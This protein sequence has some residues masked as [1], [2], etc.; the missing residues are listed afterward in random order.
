MKRQS[1]WR[2]GVVVLLLLGLLSAIRIEPEPPEDTTPDEMPGSA[3][4]LT[5]PRMPSGFIWIDQ[6]RLKR[7]P[8]E[9]SAWRNIRRAALAPIRAPNWGDQADSTNVTV[10]AKALVHARTGDPMMRETVIHACRLGI[11]SADRG[12]ALSLG[13]QLMAYVLAADLVG[14]PESLDERF[15]AELRR[16][17]AHVFPSGKT[18]QST[19]RTRPNNWGTF[20]GATRLAIAAYLGDEA[21]FSDV[22]RVFKGW[23]GDRDQYHGFDFKN[24]AW[25]ADP[26][27]PVGI[28]PSGSTRDGRSIDGVLPDDQRRGGGFQWPPPKE[29]YVYSALQGAL[30]QAVIL[31]RA[32]YPVWQWEDRALLRAFQWLHQ[33]ADYPAEGDDTWQPHIINYYYD[34]DFPARIP[35]RPGKN[36]G[37]SDWTH[38]TG[39]DPSL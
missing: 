32:G 2:A 29:N 30:A 33:E 6:E 16:L 3:D 37:W 4:A 10:L 35:T 18:L 8:V 11:G 23:L 22:A 38:P 25:Q 7:L 27:R 24:P 17:R 13:K 15:R 20:A 12:S 34:A 26:Q 39:H 21:A 9:G 1:I 5:P 28:N 19:H 36:M 31:H 14:L